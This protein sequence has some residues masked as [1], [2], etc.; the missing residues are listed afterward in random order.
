MYAVG[1]FVGRIGSLGEGV[2][3]LW[4][5]RKG[6]CTKLTIFG[7]AILLIVTIEYNIILVYNTNM[8]DVVEHIPWKQ[9][10]R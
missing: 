8:E 9:M 4:D 1:K 3:S 10:G 6:V 7:G 2:S 5:I